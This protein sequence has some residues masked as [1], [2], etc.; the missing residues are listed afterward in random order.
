M[1]RERVRLRFSKKG[2]L[3]FIGH[4]DLLN[5]MERLLRRSGLPVAMSEGF[6]PKQKVSYV[7]ALA[8]GMASDDEVMEVIFD[9]EVSV[10]EILDRLNGVSVEGLHFN[11][12][13]IL[14]EVAKKSTAESFL[15]EIPVPTDLDRD[16]ESRL[17]CLLST[18]CV[19]VA[20]SNGKI[21]DLKAPL[22]LLR[23]ENDRIILR[24]ASQA[25]PEAGV[26]EYLSYLGLDDLLFKTIFPCRKE[27][28][29]L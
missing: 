1:V 17:E 27:T 19:E 18:K 22:I 12:A 11:S 13:E 23:K 8:L 28:S 6:H 26:R 5:M 25:G 2:T 21:V 14:P 20:K 24:L 16:W 9:T 15:Y 10:G 29:L 3:R 4:R 7:S